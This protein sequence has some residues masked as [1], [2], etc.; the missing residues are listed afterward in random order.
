MITARVALAAIFALSSSNIYA[1]PPSGVGQNDIVFGTHPEEK[2]IIHNLWEDVSAIT[3]L[4]IEKRPVEVVRV[5]AERLS[6]IACGTEEAADCR[7]MA[8]Y[9]DF[10]ARKIYALDELDLGTAKGQSF[11]VHEFSHFQ[12]ISAGMFSGDSCKDVVGFERYAYDVQNYWLRSRGA[13]AVA[14]TQSENF[15]CDGR[16]L[17]EYAED[18]EGSK[19]YKPVPGVTNNPILSALNKNSP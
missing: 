6:V 14:G 17:E 3:K 12:Q 8:A 15:V 1:E 11:L 13:W 4:P 19:I 7:G 5:S 9:S 16:S 2:E 18:A 10:E